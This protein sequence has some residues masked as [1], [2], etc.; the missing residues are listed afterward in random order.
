MNHIK[1]LLILFLLA[2][3]IATQATIHTIKVWDGYF[4]FVPNNLTIQLGDT[5]QWRALDN[6]GMV[7][8]ITSKSIPTGAD[9]FDYTWQAPNDTFFQYVPKVAGNYAYVCTPHEISYNMV[10]SF[11]VT[12]GTSAVQ[13]P[14]NDNWKPSVYPN[15]TK[16]VITVKGVLHNFS[17]KIYDANGKMVQ[18]GKAEQGSI[19]VYELSKGIYFLDLIGNNSGRSPFIRLE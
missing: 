16:N 13:F 3:S 7:H 4:Q 2:Y 12:G 14:D 15:P 11:V 5:I 18:S 1:K 6:P 8:T 10:G 19:P 17:Y 9:T